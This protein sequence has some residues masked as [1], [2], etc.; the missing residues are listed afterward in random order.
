MAPVSKSFFSGYDTVQLARKLIGMR[1]VHETDDGIVGGRI[2]ETEAYLRDDPACHASRGKT[3]RNSS[4]FL[5]AG[6]AYVYLIYG[7]YCCFNV[8]S[9]EEGVGEAVLIRALEPETGIPL[10]KMRRGTED[11][12]NLASGPGKICEALGIDRSVDG[13]ALWE[14]PL[15]IEESDYNEDLDI[16]CSTRIGVGQGKEAKLRFFLRSNG[17]VSRRTVNE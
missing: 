12:V 5:E 17:H 11:E 10:M 1:L 16:A 9:C 13:H 15:Y 2:V 3:K 4:M 7:M 8:V 6:R 14:R